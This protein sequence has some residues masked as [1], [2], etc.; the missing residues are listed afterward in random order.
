[1]FRKGGEVNEGIMELAQP[2]T[3]YKTGTTEEQIQE[4]AN[5]KL[6]RFLDPKNV[7]SG[8]AELYRQRL[9]EK[10][11]V[12]QRSAQTPRQLDTG[13]PCREAAPCASRGPGWAPRP[14]R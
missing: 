2:R 11:L 1:M 7:R 3:N 8:M 9:K 6:E 13:K 14:S 5:V 10:Q 12:L 4:M